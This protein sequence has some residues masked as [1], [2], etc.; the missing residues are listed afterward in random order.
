MTSLASQ[1]W[2]TLISTRSSHTPT[3]RAY[4]LDVIADIE[5][6]QK[7]LDHSEFE[8]FKDFYTHGWT[9]FVDYNLVDVDLVDMLEEKMKLIDLGYVDGI[10]CQVQLH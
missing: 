7:K 5:L 2:T 4:R 10:R 3:G 6:G 8:T 9:K 1:S